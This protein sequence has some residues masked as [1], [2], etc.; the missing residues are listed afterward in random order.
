MESLTGGVGND[1]I[2][3]VAVLLF[4]LLGR[5]PRRRSAEISWIN[6]FPMRTLQSIAAAVT[7]GT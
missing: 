7:S 6:L 4:D 3:G 5:R 2:V 1:L